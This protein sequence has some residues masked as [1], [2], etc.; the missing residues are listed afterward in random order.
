[1]ARAPSERGRS[2]PSTCATPTPSGADKTDRLAMTSAGR[3]GRAHGRRASSLGVAAPLRAH[4]AQLLERRA[5][6]AVC[7][8]CVRAR[9]SS[10]SIAASNA[11]DDR[12]GEVARCTPRRDATQP[13]LS[14]RERACRPAYCQPRIPGPKSNL[15]AGDGHSATRASRAQP[16]WRWLRP[17]PV[18]QRRPT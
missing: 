9:D 8:A 4:V 5:G 2:Q 1:M 15:G 10:S 6:A 18:A 3:S 14:L 7:G 13:T 11:G 12:L 17:H 16:C